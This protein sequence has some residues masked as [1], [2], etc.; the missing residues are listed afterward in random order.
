[1][2]YDVAKPLVDY[3]FV[4]PP[5]VVPENMLVTKFSFAFLKQL[6]EKGAYYEGEKN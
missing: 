4:P 1:M 3:E 2:I 5:E 6:R